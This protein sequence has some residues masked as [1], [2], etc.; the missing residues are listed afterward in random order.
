MRQSV[1]DYT[2][3][4]RLTHLFVAG[5]NIGV[6]S[7]SIAEKKSAKALV[8]SGF[9][10]SL[11]EDEGCGTDSAGLEGAVVPF[12]TLRSAASLLALYSMRFCSK[13]GS[14]R[15]SSRLLTS[16]TGAYIRGQLMMH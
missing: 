10:G 12:L 14:L 11:V 13:L 6:C 4:I 16:E 15:Y 2:Q 3:D 9:D 1:A 7:S 5:L 8:P